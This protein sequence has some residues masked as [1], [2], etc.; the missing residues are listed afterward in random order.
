MKHNNIIFSFIIALGIF[1]LQSCAVTTDDDVV[2][3]EKYVG[4]WSVSDQSSRLNYSVSI[5]INPSNSAEILLNNFAD[6]NST[7]VGL[8]IGNSV[9]LD[10]QQLGSGYSVNGSGS[11]VNSGKLE[12]NFS[13][14]DGIDIESRI[15]SFTK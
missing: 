14:N 1:S 11:Y 13:L 15:A 5:T 12:F 4:T 3:M 9:V 6:L 10:S 7:A 8:V 2:D